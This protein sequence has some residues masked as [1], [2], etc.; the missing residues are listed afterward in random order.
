[1]RHWNKKFEKSLEKEFNR[2]EAASRDVIPPAAPPGE[3][4]NIM[5]EMERRGIEPRVRK[6]LKKKK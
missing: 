1:M 6:E 2:L 4:E 5:A 3:F